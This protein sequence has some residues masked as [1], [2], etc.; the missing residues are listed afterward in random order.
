MK[1]SP[2]VYL[3][4]LCWNG[5][6]WLELCLSTVLATDYP[7]FKV[8]VVD[9]NSSDDSR[10]FIKN[11]FPEVELI[12]NKKNLGC[13][14]G[15]NVGI[16][17][18]LTN[19][20]DYMILL[21]QD[22]KVEPSWLS[23]LIKVAEEDKK[24]AVLSP[25]QYDYEGK[26]IDPNCLG[27][28]MSNNQF[29]ED[30]RRNKIQNIYYL[31]R[32]ISATMMISRELVNR[33]GFMDPLYFCYHD[34]T[35]FCRRALFHGYKIVC[36]TKSIAYHF[37]GLLHDTSMSSKCRFLL[38]RNSFLY[39]LKNPSKSFWKNLFISYT[40]GGLNIIFR[41][42]S[43]LHIKFILNIIYIQ[44]WILIRLPLIAFSHFKDRHIHN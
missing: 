4:I 39:I 5:K 31:E 44:V 7:N 26:E 8:V 29:K 2:L 33:I 32:V 9:N 18:A 27:L 15:N 23:E 13:A 22:I 43:L 42:G 35:D 1:D 38:L 36:V 19:G 20:A 41:S 28:L 3:I 14:E 17:H 16:R 40:W 11:H 34:E 6:K 37:H 12:A 30:Y 21:N 24:I 25:I 10:E